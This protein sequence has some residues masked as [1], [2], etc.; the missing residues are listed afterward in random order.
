LKLRLYAPALVL[1]AWAGLA[2]LGI[3]AVAL[4]AAVLGAAMVLHARA[5][6][7]TH[8]LRQRKCRHD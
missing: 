5:L 8:A 3:E 1:F 4:F 6:S 7:T 2:A